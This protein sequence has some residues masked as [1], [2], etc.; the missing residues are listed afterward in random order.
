MCNLDLVYYTCLEGL[1]FLSHSA[2]TL[3]L[4]HQSLEQEFG[5]PSIQEVNSF[6]FLLCILLDLGDY[7][8]HLFYF[9]LRLSN[10]GPN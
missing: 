2:S 3:S 4:V 9:C 10:R 5:Q 1:V 7:I 8:H 6:I